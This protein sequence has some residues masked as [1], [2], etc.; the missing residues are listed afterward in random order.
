MLWPRVA[1]PVEV[2]AVGI[3]VDDHT[4]KVPL[5]KPA[6]ELPERGVLAQEPHVGHDLVCR[7][8]QPHR[9]NIP[10]DDEGIGRIRARDRR[11]ERVGQRI[12]EHR[13]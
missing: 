4:V 1:T 13:P 11:I 9:I 8:A 2:E 10:S 7:I 5:Q 12:D 3:R 6:D